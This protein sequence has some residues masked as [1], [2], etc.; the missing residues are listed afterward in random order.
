MGAFLVCG[1]RRGLDPSE[2]GEAPSTRCRQGK[3]TSVREGRNR[4]TGSA[5]DLAATAR[6]S[7][8]SSG[9]QEEIDWIEGILSPGCRR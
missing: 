6:R 7:A 2:P 4:T 5:G 1:R 9:T 3:E 8:S